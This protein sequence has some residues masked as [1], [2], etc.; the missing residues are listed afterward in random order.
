MRK[1]LL[2]PIAAV[3]SYLYLAPSA[4]AAIFD[5][6]KVATEF[7]ALCRASTG[8]VS[9]IIGPAI[10]FIFVI[11]V[12]IALFFLLFGAVRWITSGGDKAAIESAR[13]QIIASIVGLVIL[14]F[15]FLIFNII[16]QFFRL[17]INQLNIPQIPS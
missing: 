10:T 9:G 6:S 14:F 1:K 17:N 4:L 7:Q 11:A 8:E 5:C 2:I 13:G 16:L 12:I 15:G 3:L